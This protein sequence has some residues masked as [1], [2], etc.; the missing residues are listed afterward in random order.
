[1]F[2]FPYSC[3][4]GDFEVIFLTTYFLSPKDK[5]YEKDLVYFSNV[6]K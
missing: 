3:N 5:N 1:M 4:P 6:L 2:F